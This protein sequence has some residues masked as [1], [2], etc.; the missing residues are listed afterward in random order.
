[1]KTIISLS[2][3]ALSALAAGCDSGRWT[4]VESNNAAFGVS[5][6]APPSQKQ[7]ELDLPMGHLK[8]V[9]YMPGCVL[10]FGCVWL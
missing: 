10:V 4:E 5:M 8:V 3:V 9:E 2:L 7:T 1:M 6:R